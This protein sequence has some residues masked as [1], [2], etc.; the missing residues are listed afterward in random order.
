MMSYILLLV[1]SFDLN[2]AIAV[3]CGSELDSN[4]ETVAHVVVKLPQFSPNSFALVSEA[5]GGFERQEPTAFFQGIVLKMPGIDSTNSIL[6]RSRI[7]E[8]VNF[9]AAQAA[10]PDEMVLQQAYLAVSEIAKVWNSLQSDPELK[11][12]IEN[13]SHRKALEKALRLW[14]P[15]FSDRQSKKERV[16]RFQERA[17][18]ALSE[19]SQDFRYGR[20]VEKLLFQILDGKRMRS[21]TRSERERLVG[22]MRRSELSEDAG[23]KAFTDPSQAE[24][25]H[26]LFYQFI[27]VYNRNV[28][29][30]R[31]LDIEKIYSP[32]GVH[33]VMDR[34]LPDVKREFKPI[35][36]EVIDTKM[37]RILEK[38]TLP[39]VRIAVDDLIRRKKTFRV[40]T[41][42]RY[43]TE[44]MLVRVS[45]KEE[46]EA[47]RREI[48]SELG[49]AREDDF[50]LL[51]D[52]PEFILAPAPFTRFLTSYNH[53][54]RIWNSHVKPNRQIDPEFALTAE[55]V[56]TVIERM[57]PRSRLP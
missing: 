50:F 30:E 29:P 13:L 54:I 4:P 38:E 55:G 14:L 17:V 19:Y 33:E 5:A 51:S 18:S 28:A 31:G 43:L 45:L 27:I 9:T 11:V 39:T 57:F 16:K 53:I 1:V 24:K 44:G 48:D 2:A 41:F 22:L 32:E 49:F 20:G 42:L 34:L 3:N 56:A 8:N 23:A 21:V 40:Q 26:D 10:S 12:N 35:Q 52:E 46:I 6:L 47:L 7:R 36:E 37:A 25:V 15:E